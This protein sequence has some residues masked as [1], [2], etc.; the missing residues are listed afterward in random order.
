[1]RGFALGAL[2]CLAGLVAGNFVSPGLGKCLDIKLEKKEDGT[3]ESIDDLAEKSDPVNVQLYTCHGD[4]NQHY[5]IEGGKFKSHV[6]Q[7]FCLEAE[8]IEDNANVHFVKCEK[9]KPEQ[10][11]VLTGTGNVQFGDKCLDVK[12]EKKED[13]SREN[14][15]EIKKHKT[16]NVHLYKCH[17]PEKT[18]RV[19]Q[20]W[21][22]MPFKAGKFVAE[23]KFLLQDLGFTP[24]APAT[25][26]L[27]T[28]AISLLAAGVAIG[29]HRARRVTAL[30]VP[31]EPTE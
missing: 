30:T 22:W 7:D 2:C 1:M 20:L 10:E 17:D 26:A 27:T 5:R 25:M 18:K 16:V 19:N 9:N 14:F 21:A 29:A 4:F 8:G 11:V 28:V 13:G 24:S 15:S 12:A 3:R 6:L 31:L 23:Q